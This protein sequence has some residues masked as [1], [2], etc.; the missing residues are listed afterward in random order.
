MF[1]DET[2]FRQYSFK[3]LPSSCYRK[4]LCK[5]MSI[6][7]LSVFHIVAQAGQEQQC[8]WAE[9]AYTLWTMVMGGKCQRIC[10]C[11]LPI[12]PSGAIL[13]PPLLFVL[14]FR[15]GLLVAAGA[16]RS[17]RDEITGCVLQ[18]RPHRPLISHATLCVF[19]LFFLIYISFLF[20]L[21]P[22]YFFLVVGVG[23]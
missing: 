8:L 2:C 13:P 18:L 22:T 6:Y 5:Y 7:N 12:F 10:P 4:L 1:F 19:S 21:P 14:L 17:H 23:N 20:H 3:T 9:R 16:V 11:P 15:W